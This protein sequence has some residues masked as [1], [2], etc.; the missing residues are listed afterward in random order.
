MGLHDAFKTAV[1]FVAGIS[2]GVFWSTQVMRQDNRPCICRCEGAN[3]PGVKLNLE[4]QHFV[5][6]SNDKYSEGTLHSA[7]PSDQQGKQTPPYYSTTSSPLQPAGSSNQLCPH[8]IESQVTPLDPTMVKD[9]EPWKKFLDTVILEERRKAGWN[10]YYEDECNWV[11]ESLKSSL[12]L[13]AAS[14]PINV[15]E[16]GTAW[17]GNME[18]IARRLKGANVFAVDPLMAKY[19]RTDAMSNM[20]GKLA[21]GQGLDHV[22]F[23]QMWGRALAADGYRQ[24]GCR[25]HLV[26][27]KSVEAAPVLAR[28]IGSS[29]IDFVFVD[30]LHTY[31]GVVDD[32]AAYAPIMRPGG[33]MI[34]ND[35]GGEF[36]GV[37][38]AVDEFVSKH[39]LT[40]VVGRDSYGPGGMTSYG[41]Y[42]AGVILPRNWKR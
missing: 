37:T 40:L 10:M 39:G 15:V 36:G 3:G 8:T 23:S 38:Q 42:N 21:W 25:Y 9:T 17:G 35:Y 27:L 22:D 16:I 13:D 31:E 41:L 11:M 18:A 14:A 24:F 6:T 34:F 4:S 29:S 30:G 2:I 5:A 12:G 7:E 1:T 28:A 26:K 32:I 33:V 19:D 20:I